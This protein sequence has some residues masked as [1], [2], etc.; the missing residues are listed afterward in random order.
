MPAAT[1]WTTRLVACPVLKHD[2]QLAY[3]GMVCGQ[4][5]VQT[6]TLCLQLACM[7]VCLHD[8]AQPVYSF[9]T[10]K[11]LLCTDFAAIPTAAVRL[12]LEKPMCL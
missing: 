10:G 6:H 5:N 2:C 9:L 4:C 8:I 1:F 7:T 11:Q 12:E 3:H